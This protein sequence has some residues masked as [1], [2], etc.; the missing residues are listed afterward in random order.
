[1]VEYTFHG[2]QHFRKV[3]Y[4]FG[5][6][7]R[8]FAR[9]SVNFVAGAAFLQDHVQISWQAQTLW[10]EQHFC[11][12]NYKHF[13]KFDRGIEKERNSWQKER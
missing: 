2:A 4:R 9:A 7:C 5:G 10:Q 1:M 3:E 12:V 13:R 8:I 11:K 6:R